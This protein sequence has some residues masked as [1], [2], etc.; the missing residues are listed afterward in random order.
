[1]SPLGPTVATCLSDEHVSAGIDAVWRTEVDPALAE[2]TWQDPAL[3]SEA[4]SAPAF[5]RWAT[6]S[7]PIPSACLNPA[8]AEVYAV[9]ELPTRALSALARQAYCRRR[10]QA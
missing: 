10:R 5:W 3:A 6:T 1:M 4:V 9:A 7:S 2:T 8:L